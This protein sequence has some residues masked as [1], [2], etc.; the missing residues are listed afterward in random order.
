MSFNRKNIEIIIG[1][2][3]IAFAENLSITISV[4]KISFLIHLFRL[5]TK[6][7]TEILI[8]NR[9]FVNGY[10]IVI[11]NLFYQ[12]VLLLSLAVSCMTTFPSNT[13]AEYV[14]L[15][16]DMLHLYNYVKNMLHLFKSAR[17][18][19][20]LPYLLKTLDWSN[21]KLNSQCGVRRYRWDFL[22]FSC[23]KM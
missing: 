9:E 15:C 17:L 1:Y 14:L 2:Y 22:C 8:R 16:R 11:S 3:S 21:K 19:P 20:V 23:S 6:I 5:F 12:R 13:V 18:V 7:V 4:F 10:N